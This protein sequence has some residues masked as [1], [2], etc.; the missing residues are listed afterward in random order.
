M[1]YFVIIIPLLFFIVNDLLLYICDELQLGKSYTKPIF[2]RILSVKM[3]VVCLYCIANELFRLVVVSVLGFVIL[4]KEWK[5]KI[6][7]FWRF[8]LPRQALSR[9]LAFFPFDKTLYG[10]IN[11][12]MLIVVGSL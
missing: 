3:V 6:V 5:I 7:S 8:A 2:F 1:I 4:K 10:L 9:N 11:N 12:Q